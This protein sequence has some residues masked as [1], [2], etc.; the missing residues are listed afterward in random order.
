LVIAIQMID[1]K[2]IGG[3][4]KSQVPYTCL[5]KVFYNSLQNSTKIVII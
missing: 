3:F 5:D 1:L 4:E 2:Y